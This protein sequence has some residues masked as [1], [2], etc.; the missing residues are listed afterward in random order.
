MLTDFWKDITAF[1]SLAFSLIIIAASIALGKNDLALLLIAAL[2][3][4]YAIGFPIKVFF[5]RE[6]PNGQ[7]YSSLLS[8]YEASSFPSVHTMRAV[9]FAIVLSA[10]LES[11]LFAFIAGAIVLGVM[12]TRVRLQKHYRND[13][14]WGAVFG[15]VVGGAVLFLRSLSLVREFG[16][17]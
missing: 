14:F 7:R 8:K 6:R 13:V 11:V 16:M 3:L 12:Y 10:Y 2:A 15:I 9:S 5:F 17:L 1:G 4:C